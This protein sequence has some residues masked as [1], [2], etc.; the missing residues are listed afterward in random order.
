MGVRLIDIPGTMSLE[1]VG[2]LKLQVQ[3][4]SR[5]GGRSDSPCSKTPT[6]AVGVLEAQAS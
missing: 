1:S 6:A 4:P 5:G 2:V 3:W